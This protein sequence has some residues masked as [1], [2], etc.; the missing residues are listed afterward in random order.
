MN[1]DS[2]LGELLDGKYEVLRPLARGGM[3]AVYVA[4]RLALGDLVAVKHLLPSRDT[5]SN[6]QR[7][8]RE[9]RAAARIR[10]PGVVQIFDYGQLK[11]GG[12]YLVMEYVDGLTLEELLDR[13]RRLPPS[14][15]LELLGEICAAVEA[16]HRRGVLH[17]DLKARN[18]LVG[19]SDDGRELVKVLDFGIAHLLSAPQDARITSPHEWVGTLACSAPEQLLGNEV[20]AA[21]DVFSLGVL[22][23]QMVTGQMPFRAAHPAAFLHE[24]TQG[25]FHFLPEVEASLPREMTQTIRSALALDPRSRPESALH[26]ARSAGA[27]VRQPLSAPRSSP[28]RPNWHAFIGRKEELAR[29]EEELTPAEAEGGRIVLVTGETGVGKTRLVEQFGSQAMEQGAEVRWTRF[30]K[31]AVSRL[32]PLE[33]LL[34]LLPEGLALQ[35]RER[36]THAPPLSRSRGDDEGRWQTFSAVAECF[37]RSLPGGKCVLV[38]DDLHLASHLELDVL[39]HL[40]SE[41]PARALFLATSEG[42]PPAEGRDFDRWLTAQHR[43][44]ST[45]SLRPFSSDEVRSYLGAAFGDLRLAPPDLGQLHRASAGLPYA[46]VEAVRHLVS[47]GQIHRTDEGWRCD[48]LKLVKL[49]ENVGNLLRARFRGLAEPLK[50]LLEAAAVIGEEFSLDVLRTVAGLEE[51]ELESLVEDAERQ[52]LFTE[53][54]GVGNHFRFQNPTLRAAIYG[55]LP[56]RRRVR[57]HRSVLEALRGRSAPHSR[58]SSFALCYHCSAVGESAEALGFGLQAAEEALRCQDNEAAE[59]TLRRAQ[60]A[61]DAL[62]EEEAP[63]SESQALKLSTL[64]GTLDCRLGR[65]NR[66]SELLLSASA[67]AERLGEWISQTD[68]LFQLAQAQIGLGELEDAVKTAGAASRVARRGQDWERDRAARI[69]HAGALNR[70]GRVGEAEKMLEA[71]LMECDGTTSKRLHAQALKELA[72]VHLKA[73]SF[74]EADVGAQAALALARASGDRQ[75]EYEALSTVGV[76]KMESGKPEAAMEALTGALRLSRALF[77]RRR[78]AIDLANLGETYFELGSHQQALTQFQE[79][80]GIFKEIQDRACEGDCTVN[81]G[82]VLLSQ[83]K[84]AEAVNALERGAELCSQT[85]RAEYWGLASQC[86]AE[87]RLGAGQ[88]EEAQALFEK[89]EQLF[90]QHWPQQLW[91]AEL[92]L[93]RVAAAK[94]QTE[95]GLLYARRAAQ[96][97]TELQANLSRIPGAAARLRGAAQVAE[98]L[99]LLEGRDP[100]QATTG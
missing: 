47:E 85:G 32:P 97:V 20:S 94:C 50:G 37:Q 18:I 15:A 69:L 92:G 98:L 96:R 80:L 12:P 82:R 27:S 60:E 6:R 75:A 36:L 58:G 28:A 41:L 68:A 19:T 99:R 16:A 76:V 63:L 53:V 46:L 34:R 56:S 89:A 2:L 87:A 10:H 74:E 66:A 48:D 7:L 88:L 26:F 33:P 1:S 95:L 84:V 57:L 77:L 49:P 65:F 86:L 11:D 93:A 52:Q 70:L 67:E 17:R 38:L 4:R 39:T 61:A 79:A 100:A 35:L 90:S 8:L 14:R 71:L 5:D 54:K 55:D 40:R 64:S 43:W 44:L 3:G 51:E 91:T 29:L 73:G 72:S 42:V 22:L 9:A 62:R 31:D 25:S 21:S 30:D 81:I 78:E 23:Y 45:I 59:L 13:E 24:L 83:G